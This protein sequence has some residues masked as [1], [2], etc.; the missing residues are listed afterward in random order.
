MGLRGPLYLRHL[1]PAASPGRGFPVLP[2]D[3]HSGRMTRAS[4][5]KGEQHGLILEKNRERFSALFAPQSGGVSLY[6]EPMAANLSG[7]KASSGAQTPFP[8]SR[9]FLQD[10]PRCLA[11]YNGGKPFSASPGRAHLRA[12]RGRL[13]GADRRHLLKPWGSDQWTTW[14][15]GF[16]KSSTG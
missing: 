3:R 14:F 4:I 13:A 5:N 7:G 1:R 9:L 11:H 2:P 6:S 12:S 16:S 8:L 10:T 15:A